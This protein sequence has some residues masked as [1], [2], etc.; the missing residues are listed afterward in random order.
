MYRK[1]QIIII[2]IINEPFCGAAYSRISGY[3]VY[4]FGKGS[5]LTEYLKASK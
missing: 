3:I 1:G 2:I 4:H 5:N